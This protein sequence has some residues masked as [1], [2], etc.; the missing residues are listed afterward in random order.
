MLRFTK[1]MHIQMEATV[2]IMSG[3]MAISWRLGGDFHAFCLAMILSS[4]LFDAIFG[5]LPTITNIKMA[6]QKTFLR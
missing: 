3:A 4:N 1:A 5:H 6:N 2:P